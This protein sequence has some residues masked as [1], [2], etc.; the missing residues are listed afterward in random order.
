M[1]QDMSV[2]DGASQDEQFL[3][4]NVLLADGTHFTPEAL[5]GFRIMELI[6]AYGLPIKAECGGAGVCATCHVR[7][8]EA[9]RN[10]LP[11]PS[12]EELEKLDEIPGAD[13][14]SRLACQIMMAPELDGL[15]LEIQPDSLTPQ[16]YWA[17][18]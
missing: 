17:A 12:A 15:E 16:T 9:W 5:P 13:E 8:P 4:L 7:V 6:R 10:L 1:P 18:G 2:A 11:P 14:S 3:R